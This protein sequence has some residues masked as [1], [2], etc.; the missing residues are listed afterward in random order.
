MRRESFQRLDGEPGI[1]YL[2]PAVLSEG[3]W[4]GHRQAAINCVCRRDTCFPVRKERITERA[5][6]ESVMM[7]CRN[8]STYTGALR[9]MRM[10]WSSVFLLLSHK[11]KGNDY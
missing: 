5:F 8:A 4:V 2:F 9:R 3:C 11:E 10:T 6:G 1:P 7:E